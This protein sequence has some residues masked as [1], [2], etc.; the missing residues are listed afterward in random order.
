MLALFVA[1]G[2][3]AANTAHA[4]QVNIP[5][6]FRGATRGYENGKVYQ[7]DRGT[8]HYETRERRVWVPEQRTRGIFGTRVTP[9]H[10]ETIREQVKVYH[11][12]NNRYGDD[13]YRGKKG[14]PHGM[15][16]GQ[17]K[18]SGNRRYDDDRYDDRRYDDR[19]YD[20]RRYDDR[21]N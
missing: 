21:R 6:V 15:P 8:Y 11:N 9:G 14:H 13:R 2:A 18:K 4:Q 20:D 19:R 12:R 5:E 10:Y 3:T 17:R 1:I 16:P 7:D